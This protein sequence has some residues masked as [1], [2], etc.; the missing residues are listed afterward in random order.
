MNDGTL[1]F[2]VVPHKDIELSHHLEVDT[3]PSDLS[4]TS[5]PGLFLRSD[6][7]IGRPRKLV[8]IKKLILWILSVSSSRSRE[9]VPIPLGFMIP[10]ISLTYVSSPLSSFL[11][12]V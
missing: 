11:Y 12:Y 2:T 3:L 1:G 8:R 6:E 9:M 4:S 7:T 10:L 5:Y